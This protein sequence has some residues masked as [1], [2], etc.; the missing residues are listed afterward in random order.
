MVLCSP[1]D[2]LPPF[3]PEDTASSC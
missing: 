3:R 1:E 2:C